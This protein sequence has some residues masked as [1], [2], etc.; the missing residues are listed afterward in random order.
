MSLEQWSQLASILS[1]G[2][3]IV[4]IILVFIIKD[5]IIKIENKVE[6]NEQNNKGAI[7]KSQK[8][9]FNLTS[10]QSKINKLK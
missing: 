1:F 3:S 8:N 5:K 4:S 7:I 2:T 10:D 9:Y 6:N